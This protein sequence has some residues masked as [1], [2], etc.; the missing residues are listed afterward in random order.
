VTYR[1]SAEVWRHD[2]EAAWYFVTL[3]GDIAD[4]I[5]FLTTDTR[6]GFGSVRVEVSIGGTTWRTSIFP[7][8]ARRSYLLPVKKSVRAAEHLDDGSVTEVELDLIDE[9]GPSGVVQR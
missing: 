7:D 3:P 1:F 5:D 4:E 6:R 2:G 8:N 9:V